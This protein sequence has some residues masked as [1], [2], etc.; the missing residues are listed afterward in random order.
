[1]KIK[2]A[3]GIMMLLVCFF[4][5]TAEAD[6]R[7]INTRSGEHESFT[8]IVLDSE[9][10]YPLSIEH[11][12]GNIIDIRY[13][14]LNLTEQE[15]KRLM[16]KIDRVS[17]SEIYRDKIFSHLRLIPRSGNV[18]IKT[19]YL[20]PKNPEENGYRLVID[21]YPDTAVIAEENKSTTPVAL[22]K[23]EVRKTDPVEMI[24]EKDIQSAAADKKQYEG[25]DEIDFKNRG[26]EK[27]PPVVPEYSNRADPANENKSTVQP[28][29]AENEIKANNPVGEEKEKNS[30]TMVPHKKKISGEADIVLRHT[31]G[32]KESSKFNEYGDRAQAVTG[33]LEINRVK[34][35]SSEIHFE[36][37]DIGQDDQSVLF[38]GNFPG[39]AKVEAGYSELPHR[40]QYGAKTLYSGIG[41]GNLTLD[42][43][44]R[45]NLASTAFPDLVNRLSYY[46]SN[47]FM[48]DPTVTRKKGYLNIDWNKF[49]PFGFSME[50]KRENR[51]GT[52]PR[53]GS[54]GFS[55]TVELPEPVDYD[56]LQF[57]FNG[58]YNKGSLYLSTSYYFSTFDNNIKTL[59]WD[60]PFA[61]NDALFN[62]S[63]GRMS[64]P[65]DNTYH[66][67]SM[68]G[69]LGNL[70]YY[71]RISANVA[72]GWMLQDD[73]LAPYTIDSAV[74]A[75]DVPVDNIDGEIKTRLINLLVTSNPYNSM[76]LKIK[77]KSYE[78]KN[79]TTPITFPGY[80]D[81]DSY[82]ISTPVISPPSSYK[83]NTLDAG[84]RKDIL[85][86]MR[87]AF[88]YTWN[89]M[90]RTNREVSKQDD[91]GFKLAI[92]STYLAWLYFRTSYERVKRD[93]ENYVFD[94]YLAS[95][96]DLHQNPL[97]RKYDEADM[98][99]DRLQLNA[100]IT[101]W[102]K[103]GIS[104]SYIYGR[105]D[106]DN[107]TYGLLEDKHHIFTV[108]A[109][110]ALS[111]KTGLHAFYSNENYKNLTAGMDFTGDW[112]V[113]GNDRVDT[114][115]GNL[116]TKLIDDRLSLDIS[117]S[118]SKAEGNLDFTMNGTEYSQFNKV[119]DSR[120]H[121]FET[122]MK[123]RAGEKWAYSLGFLWEKARYSDYD[124]E[125]FTYVPSNTLGFYQG[126]LLMGIIHQDYDVTQVYFKLA[127]FF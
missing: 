10:A 2:A 35:N 9:G 63:R 33:N 64:L 7:L 43:A 77:F 90:E 5:V 101:P 119:D 32:D 54:L 98:T 106:F 50:F 38:K 78:H 13:A 29:P 12:Q 116:R 51:S 108:D 117:Y 19:T 89:N 49:D 62:S 122:E 57:R 82:F 15:G 126:A 26:G 109:D 52:I 41:T 48:G 20:P 16:E 73:S 112:T 100:D 53:F 74:S 56:S 79:N 22:A 71:T 6:T 94:I 127:H 124:K 28:I 125:G 107:S 42:D 44:I 25:E 115:G 121:I 30:Q 103:F 61:L 17:D 47:A 95:G 111:E 66:N 92:D 1:M 8:R 18:K 70:P 102:D 76:N 55:N 3:T 123:Y 81:T 83:K 104:L 46:Y 85:K 80:V 27:D 118:Y 86:D 60:N 93:T 21:M 24:K 4:A 87:L 67:V 36:M 65:P 23:T 39:T 91:Q 40:Y 31:S 88:N 11:D 84:F 69:V 110:Y 99:R 68:T 37:N 45:G 75:P 72:L 58:E 113:A 97:L 114:I 59:S 14:N 34:E 105:D 120:F 96:E